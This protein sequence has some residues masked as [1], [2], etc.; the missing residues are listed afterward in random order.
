MGSGGLNAFE[1]M[2]QME[3]PDFRGRFLKLGS[4]VELRLGLNAL[5]ASPLVPPTATAARRARS[6]GTR[7]PARHALTTLDLS[8]NRLTELGAVNM[9]GFENVRTL[10]AGGNRI[11]AVPSGVLSQLTSLRK[12]VLRNI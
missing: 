8:R 3:L 9:T 6:G 2:Q 10:L 7:A 1:K 12:L 11:T 5:A 4:L